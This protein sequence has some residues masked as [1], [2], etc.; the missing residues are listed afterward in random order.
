M[1]VMVGM[2][3]WAAY[4]LVVVFS[5]PAARQVSM[6]FIGALAGVLATGWLIRRRAR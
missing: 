6:V 1:E 2:I 4:A 5:T 3:L